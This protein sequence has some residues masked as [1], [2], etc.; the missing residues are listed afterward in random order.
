M[1]TLLL[2]L[3]EEAVPPRRLVPKVP[4]DLETICLKCLR[5]EPDKRYA[6]AE[7]LAGDL[8]R[9][10]REEPIAARPV[11]GLER[12]IK[13]VRRNPAI[14]GLEIAVAVLLV[15]GSVV[16]TFFGVQALSRAREARV[17][18][19]RGEDEKRAADEARI[20]AESQ[21]QA[22]ENARRNA[23][24]KEK[25][26]EEARGRADF[27]KTRADLEKKRAVEQLSRTELTLYASELA[28]AQHAWQEGDRSRALEILE[29][30]QWNLR[31][32]EFDHLWTLYHKNQ[33]KL[34]EH[35]AGVSCVAF[36]PDGKRIVSGSADKML[37]V[38]DVDKSAEA[39]M[40]D[41]R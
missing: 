6:S 15:L 13:W 30:C 19:Q 23:E 1:D 10:R 27:E 2:V 11:G 25:K 28:K 7:A 3:T 24:D 39:G 22:A 34:R 32:V 37:K 36:S 41:D 33:Q 9:F 38:W 12:G 8:A 14:A 5:K 20:N 29:G 16:S 31:N 40:L 4:P 18:V 35:T 26:A 17:A 21:K